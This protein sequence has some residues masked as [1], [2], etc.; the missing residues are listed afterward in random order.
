MASLHQPKDDLYDLLTSRHSPD[1]IRTMALENIRK[2]I[3]KYGTEHLLDALP[4][5]EDLIWI[6]HSAANPTTALVIGKSE[7]CHIVAYLTRYGE[8][9]REV[10]YC[11]RS[12]E[13]PSFA[14]P[15]KTM[16]Q[17]EVMDM[18]LLPPFK[19]LA[20]NSKPMKR[21]FSMLV[22]WYFLSKGVINNIEC[23]YDDFCKRFSQA[24]RKID[25]ERRAIESGVGVDSSRRRDAVEESPDPDEV[26]SAYGLRSASR[27]GTAE[28]AKGTEIEQET[29]SKRTPGRRKSREPNP[30]LHRLREYLHLHD[31]LYLLENIHDAEEMKFFDQTYIPDAQ[32][33]KL[34]I[35][36][37]SK[38]GD[39][40]YA[41]MVQLQR[42]FHQIRFIVE[43]PRSK[44]TM[45]AEDISRQHILH[46][47]DKTYPKH[48]AIEQSD[49]ARLTLI[50]KW[51]FI[52]ADLATDCVL[53][54]T[55]AYPERLLSALEYIA[56]RMGPGAVKPPKG[57]TRGV[58]NADEDST[59]QR[60]T[61]ESSYVDESDIQSTLA[62]DPP[63]V[64]PLPTGPKK[65]TV[66]RKS[67]PSFGRKPT[68][69]ATPTA[70]SF[71]KPAAL[72]HPP[73]VPRITKTA[74]PEATPTPKPMPP[75]R[76]AKRTA[77]DAEFE[78]LSAMVEEE[79]KLTLQ[80]NDMDHDL[81]LLEL[82]KQ[83][84]MEKWENETKA[85]KAKRDRLQDERSNVRGNFMGKRQRLS[86]AV[87]DD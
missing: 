76:T 42:G 11:L 48:G 2:R 13:A 54:E 80:M 19:H 27:N 68:P 82:K 50:V 26:E 45:H 32:P 6:Q 85:L 52:A 44:E 87:D 12:V 3:I 63:R 64:S 35:G 65:P 75:P 57:I 84:F 16:P 55:K 17:D 15:I 47:F 38:S 37:H 79:K 29:P 49:R 22:R 39:D 66:A 5:P 1:T 53:K 46:P 60:T 59:K 31:A 81:E 7:G 30:D 61:S 70:D 4:L 71:S 72:S 56:D 36:H 34:F 41:Y 67:A 43:G 74:T 86:S 21:K 25:E 18:P 40:I 58:P 62:G 33:K 23:E 20:K 78:A 77:E 51:Y 8:K 73:S 28:N 24:L 14:A 10:R 83:A 9:A 69:L